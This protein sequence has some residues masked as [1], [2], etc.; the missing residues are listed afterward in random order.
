MSNREAPPFGIKDKLGYMLGD[1]ANDFSFIFA[2]TFV[3]VFY[4][5]VMGI[6]TGMI[7]TMFLVARFIDAFTDIGMGRIADRA[8]TGKSGKFRPWILRMCGPVAIA[9]FL[10]YQSG[11]QGIPYGAKV[12]YMFVTYI[13]WGSVFYTSINIPYGSM[14]SVISQNPKDRSS[15]S[16][17]R[18][19]GGMFAGNLISVVAPLVIYYKDAAGNQVVNSTN[20]TILAGIFSLCAILCYL[21]CYWLCTE[22]VVLPDKKQAAEKQMSV[23]ASLKE[24]VGS[25][26]LLGV[27]LS[28]LLLLLASLMSQGLNN[29]L[30]ADYFKNTQAL[31]LSAMLQ[32]PVMLILA[33]VSTK[34]AVKFG[35]RECG[36]AGMLLSGIL[37]VVIGILH[38]TQV[39]VFIGLVFVAMIGMTFFT[40]Q[41]FALVT[42]V[43]DD[44][45]VITGKRDDGTI[46]GIYS[47]SRKIGQALAGGMGGWALALIGYEELA[48]AQTE[49][50]ARGIYNIS[51]FFP[52]VVYLLGAAVLF[53]IYPLSKRRV[54]SNAAELKRRHNS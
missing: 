26:A 10:M 18:S 37:Y 12:A 36:V 33:A 5:K 31:S 35:K 23:L 42:D 13:L 9:S 17:F 6:S 21:L 22:R 14:A 38:V 19:M 40:M 8:K 50:V 2:S 29:Y 30:Y 47:F 32:L 48:V 39:W 15:L 28:A 45:E 44:K 52:G 16:V 46:Y 43:I 11:L 7:G 34:L 51:T 41:C 1:V 49:Q 20:F 54:E 53:F 27:I 3:M 4:S 25:R 24:V